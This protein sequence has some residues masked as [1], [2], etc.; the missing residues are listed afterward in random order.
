MTAAMLQLTHDDARYVARNIRAI[1]RHE[2][3]LTSAYGEDTE[4]WAEQAFSCSPLAWSLWADG[5]PVAVVGAGQMHPGVWQVFMF[6]TEAWPRGGREMTR[7][8]VR[9]M[10]P[11]LRACGAHRAQCLS[12]AAHTEAHA[13]LRWLGARHE[14]TLKGYGRD[15]SDFLM[16]AWTLDHVQGAKGSK[17]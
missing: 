9:C 10:I 15:G 4:A 6:A 5:H 2:L 8:L 12:A 13:W 17:G 1:D 3:A 11:L 14:A 7:F 16:F